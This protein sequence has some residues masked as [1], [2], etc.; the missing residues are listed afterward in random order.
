MIKIVFHAAALAALVGADSEPVC[1][2]EHCS[3]GVEDVA[4]LQ[5]KTTRVTN[6]ESPAVVDANLMARPAATIVA[7]SG[8]EPPAG[9]LNWARIAT[10]LAD[11]MVEGLNRDFD[12]FSGQSFAPAP[13]PGT[14]A[15]M[16]P[17][18][19]MEALEEGVS[20]GAPDH[21]D[22]DKDEDGHHRAHHTWHK[23][24]F[25]SDETKHPT[26]DHI[27]DGDEG[28]SFF[29][30][31]TTQQW[32]ALIVF[33]L[34]SFVFDLAVL[35]RLS[36]SFATHLA[37]IGIWIMA[38][39]VFNAWIFATMGETAG[40]EWC[41]GYFL[42]WMLSMDNLFVFH[43]IFKKYKTPASQTHYA[44]FVGIFGAL[45]MRMVFFM[46]LSTLLHMFH[47]IRIPFGALLIW[48][49][50]DT[51]M[52]DDDD[53]E[54]KDLM[55]VRGLKAVL[56]SR[57]ADG[58]DQ[59][60]GGLFMWGKDGRLQATL[61]L[62]VVFCLEATDVL[63]ALDSVSAKV[64]Q[65]PNQY[66][67]FSSSVIAMFGLRAIFFIIEDLVDMFHL[68]AYGLCLILVFIGLQLIFAKWLHMPASTVCILIMSVFFVCIAGSWV[69]KKPEAEEE[70]SDETSKAVK[71]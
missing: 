9:A 13:A 14:L 4:Y 8:P 18:P 54:V 15:V 26:P 17:V 33:C 40:V 6:V 67:S 48:S 34:V 52:A 66:L 11:R 31:A 36:G 23:D 58:Y 22:G 57:L 65:I 38:A 27:K 61:L 68:L 10:K 64:A 44:V 5:S 41:S 30:A 3:E 21:G 47:W 42:E 49:G 56:G 32:V 69:T 51:A 39:G 16:P 35:Q 55:L 25:D 71:A 60:G 24:A 28:L 20:S 12:P 50:I 59:Q 46:V 29:R 45:V 62:I 1:T 43:L 53:E 37:C 7:A 63:F 2:A 19:M 70:A